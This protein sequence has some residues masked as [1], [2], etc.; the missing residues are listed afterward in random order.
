MRG[1]SEGVVLRLVLLGTHGLDGRADP[2][3]P[4]DGVQRGFN[5]VICVAVRYA[6]T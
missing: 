2:D 4:R 5:S 6:I 1:V 3:P